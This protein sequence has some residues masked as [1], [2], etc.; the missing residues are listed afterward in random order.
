MRYGKPVIG[1]RI[2]GMQEVIDDNVTGL[3][4]EPN[5]SA[6]FEACLERLLGDDQMRARM[7]EAGRS[8]ME[9]MFTV[10]TMCNECADIYKQI[11]QIG[12]KRCKGK[13]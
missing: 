9:R 6:S 12:K 5:D 7:G 8:R 1:C 11:V 13:N 10:E 2:G 3:L 4:A